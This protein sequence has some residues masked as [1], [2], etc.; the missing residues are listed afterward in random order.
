MQKMNIVLFDMDNTLVS[1]DTVGLWAEFLDQ[2]G[3]L[4]EQD[5]IKRA[6]F[7]N[8][9]IE[10]RIDIATS[11]EF[12]LSL[13]LKV[14]AHLREPWRQEFFNN[15][16]KEKITRLG[17]QLIHNY[18]K[19]PNTLVLLITATQEFLATPVAEH[20][21]VHSLIATQ[22]EIIDGEYT[23]KVAGIANMGEGKVKNFNAW[24]SQNQITPTHTTLYSDSIN[25]LPLLSLVNKPIAVDPDRRLHQVALQRKWEIISLR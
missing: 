8:A 15:H 7:D 4:T 16:V 19:Q 24:L 22:E 20:A 10:N 17:L 18:K 2:K 9:Y 5:R 23:G 6:H 11:Y 21:K 3:I 12:D 13:F 14:P 25:D 1:T